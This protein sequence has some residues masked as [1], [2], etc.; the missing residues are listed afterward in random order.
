MSQPT[1]TEPS[2]GVAAYPFGTTLPNSAQVVDIKLIDHDRAIVLAHRGES[3]DPWVTWALHPAHP[4]STYNGRYFR[5]LQEAAI[6]FETR[7]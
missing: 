1:Y 4:N 3:Y 5:T 6:D 7:S 2:R